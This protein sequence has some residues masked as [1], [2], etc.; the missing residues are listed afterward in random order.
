MMIDDDGDD[1][2]DDDDDENDD[3]DDDMFRRGEDGA[4]HGLSSKQQEEPDQARGRRNRESH[5]RLSQRPSKNGQFII[6]EEDARIMPGLWAHLL[7]A[8]AELVGVL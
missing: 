3:D 6:S 4:R 8:F 5:Q 1:D 7:G 2:D